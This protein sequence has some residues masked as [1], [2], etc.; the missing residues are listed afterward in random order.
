MGVNEWMREWGNEW[1]SEWGTVIV[2]SGEYTKPL[3]LMGDFSK[4]GVHETDGL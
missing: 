3:A 4:G 2:A 1:M